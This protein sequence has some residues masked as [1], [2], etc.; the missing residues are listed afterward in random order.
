MMQE[1]PSRGQTHC[2]SLGMFFMTCSTCMPQPLQVY[3][4]ELKVKN[5][6]LVRVSVCVRGGGT[7]ELRDQEFGK[8]LPDLL[9]F[10]TC[11]KEWPYTCCR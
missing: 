8:R 7:E 2:W 4:K 9:S 11:G 1:E 3:R 5:G 6:C 10:R